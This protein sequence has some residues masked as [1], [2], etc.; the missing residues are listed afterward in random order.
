[1]RK[2]AAVTFQLKFEGNVFGYLVTEPNAPLIEG[3]MYHF[4]MSMYS[5]KVYIKNIRQYKNPYSL[6]SK[7]AA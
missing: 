3:G 1:M 4:E 5:N 7:I 6:T 2:Y